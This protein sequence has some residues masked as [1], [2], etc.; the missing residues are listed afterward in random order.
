MEVADNSKFKEISWNLRRHFILWIGS[1]AERHWKI[2]HTIILQSIDFLGIL[3]S[4]Y[5]ALA[6]HGK[7][8]KHSDYI[9]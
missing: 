6:F 7:R 5:E 1:T 3:K 4:L 2:E 9:F 8:L